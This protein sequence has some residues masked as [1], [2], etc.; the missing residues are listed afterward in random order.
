VDDD[1]VAVNYPVSNFDR[2][3]KSLRALS[4]AEAIEQGHMC[5]AQ[6]ADAWADAKAYKII[7][8]LEAYNNHLTR[9]TF[10]ASRAHAFYALAAVL[11]E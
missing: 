2:D 9:A 11:P 4:R 6:A 10:H 8:R 5:L 3:M 1:D 7:S